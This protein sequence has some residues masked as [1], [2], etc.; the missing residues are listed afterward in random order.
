MDNIILASDYATDI[1]AITLADNKDHRYFESIFWSKDQYSPVGIAEL[2]CP[3]TP[4]TIKYWSSYCDVVII[5]AVVENTLD[6]NNTSYNYS[7]IGKI[8]RLKQKGFK[9]HII[10]EDLGWKF[11]QKVP[12]EFRTSYIAGQRLDDAFQAICEFLGVEFAYSIEDLS[13]LTFAPDGYSVQKDGETIEEVPSMFEEFNSI[14]NEDETLLDKQ[15]YENLNLINK[16]QEL[17]KNKDKSKKTTHDIDS[18][19]LISP[20]QNQQQNDKTKTDTNIEET[21][22]SINDK[23]EQFQEEFDEKIKD[24]FI[25][26]RY[27]ESD[28]ISNVLNYG[29]ITIT[30]SALDTFSQMNEISNTET[31]T[32]TIEQLNEEATK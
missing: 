24:L 18:V 27:Y 25:G 15:T 31:T 4:D 20:A 1:A 32:D 30:P 17:E 22:D 7:F 26:N 21:E 13:E 8:N 12:R 2:V 14:D 23:I 9:L 11:M 16:K 28:L 10:L 19:S 3:Y 5:S 29:S 6:E